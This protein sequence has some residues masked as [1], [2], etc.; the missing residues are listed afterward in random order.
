[1]SRLVDE[2][3]SSSTSCVL[4]VDDWLDG[5]TSSFGAAIDVG[6]EAVGLMDVGRVST[7]WPDERLVDT[8]FFE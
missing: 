4:S 8:P 5:M 3:E 6:V 2:V 1:M 7:V